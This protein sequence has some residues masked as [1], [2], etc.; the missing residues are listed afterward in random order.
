MPL[1]IRTLIKCVVVS[2]RRYPYRNPWDLTFLLFSTTRRLVLSTIFH[3]RGL[4]QLQLQVLSSST[5]ASRFQNGMMGWA[6]V[7]NAS[8]IMS[9]VTTGVSIIAFARSSTAWAKLQAAE[10]WL[11]RVDKLLKQLT[12]EQEDIINKANP[13]ALEELRSTYR[14]VLRKKYIFLE[15]Y[16]QSGFMKRTQYW[17]EIYRDANALMMASEDLHLDA[18]KTT[19]IVDLLEATDVQSS[20]IDVADV[21]DAIEL[22]RRFPSGP[23][24]PLHHPPGEPTPSL[25]ALPTATR[26][27]SPSNTAPQVAPQVTPLTPAVETPIASDDVVE[28]VEAATK[29]APVVDEYDEACETV[30]QDMQKILEADDKAVARA[31]ERAPASIEA[32]R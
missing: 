17:G 14:S 31:P 19:K 18:M 27:T 4:S 12:P 16:T 6:G 30:I 20:P 5:L 1:Q 32:S 8:S 24:L 26:S 10:S 7:N 28:E 13:A 11:E 15:K 2:A 23:V 9:F 25:P 29:A 21:A 22:Q 3:N